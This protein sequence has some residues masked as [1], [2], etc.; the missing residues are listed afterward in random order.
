MVFRRQN[1]MTFIFI[2][3]MSDDLSVQMAYQDRPK[4]FRPAEL[5]QTPILIPVELN[6]K[7]EKYSIWWNC[8]QNTLL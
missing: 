4:L 6:S 3:M 5:I 1:H 2:E 8:L 7:G